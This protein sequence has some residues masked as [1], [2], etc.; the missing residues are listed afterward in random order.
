MTFTTA[1]DE[2]FEAIA[3]AI[4]TALRSI[5]RPAQ[6]P[7]P[8][9]VAYDPIGQT[10][11]PATLVVGEF[12]AGGTD[13]RD[14]DL[15][16]GSRDAPCEWQ[17]RLYYSLQA[18]EVAYPETRAIAGMVV[19]VIKADYTLGGEVEEASV[20]RIESSPNDPDDGDRLLVTEF[21]I[22]TIHLMSNT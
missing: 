19:Q 8:V 17:V 15:Q 21:T 13:V 22:S 5:T 12:D 3:Q 14:R 11:A 18:P 7:Q 1:P 9:V 16:L 2:K 10:L 6:F 20:I 4:A